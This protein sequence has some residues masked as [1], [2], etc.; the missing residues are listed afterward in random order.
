MIDDEATKNVVYTRGERN[1]FVRYTQKSGEYVWKLCREAGVPGTYQQLDKWLEVITTSPSQDLIKFLK[2]EVQRDS[3]AAHLIL[4]ALY[5]Q[6]KVLDRSE[7]LALEH[8]ECKRF[9]Y[10]FFLIYFKS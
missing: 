8:L 6:G 9:I 5:N 7:R 3:P 10:L 2:Q 4:G 1:C